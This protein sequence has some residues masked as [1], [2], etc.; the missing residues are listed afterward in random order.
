M[1]RDPKP[2]DS[3]REFAEKLLFNSC[4]DI[5]GNVHLGKAA[6]LIAARDC[7]L[8]RKAQEQMREKVALLKYPHPYVK[9]DYGQPVIN[10]LCEMDRKAIRALP[11]DLE[12]GDDIC[13]II[14]ARDRDLWRKAQEQMR[15]KAITFGK[16]WC[17]GCMKGETFVIPSPSGIVGQAAVHSSGLICIPNT[18]GL[19]PLDPL[20]AGDDGEQAR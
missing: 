10:S 15:E 8:W 14:A 3:A 9:D 18:L 6:E 12:Q 13:G 16:K 11:L 7:D 5:C 17:I 1:Y 4:V 19:L 20:P 2:L